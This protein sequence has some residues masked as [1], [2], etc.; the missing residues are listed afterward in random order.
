MKLRDLAEWVCILVIAVGAG[1]VFIPAGV[2]TLGV[3]S[4][5]WLIWGTEVDDGAE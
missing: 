4:L 3:L 1:L 2:I 5:A